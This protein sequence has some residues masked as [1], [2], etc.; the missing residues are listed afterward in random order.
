MFPGSLDGK[1]V[2][3]GHSQGGHSALSALALAGTY[4]A[5]DINVAAVAVFAPLW[6][7]QATWGALLYEAVDYPLGG[8]SA[9]PSPTAISIWF[10]Y[11]NGELMDGPGH[12]LD[13]F[14]ASQQSVITH[15]ID[16]DCWAAG[17]SGTGAPDSWDSGTM[18][19]DL[20]AAG[21]DALSFFDPFFANAIEK[22]AAFGTTSRPCGDDDAGLLCQKWMARYAADR[23]HLSNTPPILIS[24]GG[25]DTTLIPP[26]MQC[27]TQRLQQDNAGYSFCLD[28]MYGHG[29]NLRA[30]ADYAA[31]W[32]GA[33]TLGETPPAACA[34]TDQNLT[35]DGGVNGVPIACETPPPNN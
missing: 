18:Y 12:G 22:S 26:L 29:G 10:H 7:S 4:G 9:D 35:S 28:P 34:L 17:W 14:S 27:V 33:Q 31:D 3:V 24:Y 2:L 8:A 20:Q 13:P 23:P 30:H 5:P 6:F 32:I 21:T 25:A 11:T 15:F 16:N 19:P 1:V